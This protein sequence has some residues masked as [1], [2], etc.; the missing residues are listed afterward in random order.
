MS[1]LN[2]CVIEF[3]VYQTY[4]FPFIF[5]VE[6]CKINIIPGYHKK[7]IVRNMS[8]YNL[9]RQPMA[10]LILSSRLEKHNV[11]VCVDTGRQPDKA[12]VIHVCYTE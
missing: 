10:I 12:K 4:G 1:I 6:R 8:K 7:F 3:C 5:D 11:C 9:I 2:L